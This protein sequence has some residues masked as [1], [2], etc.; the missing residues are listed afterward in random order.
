MKGLINNLRIADIRKDKEKR[1]NNLRVAENEEL[2]NY[3][4]VRRRVKEGRVKK[5]VL[6]YSRL[7]LQ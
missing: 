6:L 2:V 5:M 3:W 1:Q 7:V 4:V